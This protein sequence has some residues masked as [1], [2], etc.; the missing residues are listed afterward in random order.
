MYDNDNSG[1]IKIQMSND[2]YDKNADC[3][4][5]TAKK[6]RDRFLQKNLK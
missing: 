1:S 4:E 5:K 3:Q 2:T 6:C